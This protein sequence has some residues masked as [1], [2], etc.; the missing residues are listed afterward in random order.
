MWYLRWMEKTTLYLPTELQAGLRDISR[1]TGRSQAALI[2]E[3]LGQYIAAQER[4]WPRS[5]GSAADGTVSGVE[6]EEWLRREWSRSDAQP[7]RR[8][9]RS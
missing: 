4:P 9:R 3:A 5:I 2:R 1:R 6:S 8:S 7:I